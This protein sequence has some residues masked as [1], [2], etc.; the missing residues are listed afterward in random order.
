[1]RHPPPLSSSL[2]KGPSAPSL[3]FEHFSNSL[4]LNL[5]LDHDLNLNLNLNLSRHTVR[6]EW[7]HI[8]PI[9]FCDRTGTSHLEVRKVK[10]KRV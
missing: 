10:E 4:D 5:N 9:K 1:M 3:Y 2:G 8:N 7:V 6:S